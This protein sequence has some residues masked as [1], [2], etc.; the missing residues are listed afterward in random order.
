MPGL[1]WVCGGGVG[2][3]GLVVFGFDMI[4]G[5][6]SPCFCVQVRRSFGAAFGWCRGLLFFLFLLTLPA[7]L[8]LVGL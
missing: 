6:A 8:G 1:C 2:G 7:L 5:D 4:C 3:H